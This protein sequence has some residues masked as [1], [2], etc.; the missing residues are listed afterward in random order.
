M[1]EVKPT[2][3]PVPSS[4]IKDLFFNS[5]LLD[6]WATSLERK[7]IDRFGNCHLTAAGMEWLF[8]ELIE[9]FK[10]DMNTA[11]VAAG[12]I[13][14]DSFQQGADLPN[15]E[16]TQRNHILRDE[17]TGEYYRWDGDLP[18]QVPAGSIPQSTGG[19]GKGAWVSVGDASLRGELD[20]SSG[21]EIIGSHDGNLQE[22]LTEYKEKIQTNEHIAL[23]ANSMFP[24]SMQS[25][26][27][28]RIAVEVINSDPNNNGQINTYRKTKS[29]WWLRER[30]V[31]GGYSG[32]GLGD[33]GCPV[34]RLGQSFIAPHLLTMKSALSDKSSTWI[35]SYSLIPNQFING[36]NKNSVKFHQVQGGGAGSLFIEF[37]TNTRLNN[38][39]VLLAGTKTT[40]SSIKAEIRIG[41]KVLSTET[42][43]STT[44]SPVLATFIHQIKNPRPGENI[45]VRFTT[46]GNA[47][48]YIAGINAIFDTDISDDID[49]INFAIYNQNYLVRP[50]QTGAMCYVFKE[51][52]SGL[53]GGESHGGE[54]PSLQKFIVNN[55]EAS[56]TT[57]KMFSCES[58]RVIQETQ[59]KWSDTKKI[60][61]FTEHKF[62]GDGTHEFTGSFAPTE[63]FEVSLA[64]CPMFTVNS[65]YFR[66][67]KVPEFVKLDSLVDGAVVDIKYPVN[68]FEMQGADGLYTAGIMW[69]SSLK[70]NGLQRTFVNPYGDSSTKMYAG[71]AID[72]VINLEKFTIHQMRYYF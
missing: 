23:S 51:L 16:L 30:I 26:L 61:C 17:T 7:Y 34:W 49:T 52:D 47:W 42:I 33:N 70:N 67:I 14:I 35:D 13:T 44:D 54:T 19:I 22:V 36:N 21:A 71:P 69:S 58:F 37:E 24:K 53:F 1:R 60:D 31:T 28:G 5:G 68:Q 20:S 32:S 11:I 50:T 46:T 45:K 55:K 62:N 41:D 56:L 2:Q 43:D 9:K 57:G 63:G 6:I 3:K 29:G 4:D 65:G 48:A 59:I 72:K 64:Y 12:Y 40:N 38:I 15:N 10:V 39:N 66:R 25:F 27:N 18:K 8:K